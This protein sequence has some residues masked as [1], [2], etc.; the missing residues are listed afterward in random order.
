MIK[1]RVIV[2]VVLWA[3]LTAGCGG[4][5]MTPQEEASWRA[6]RW[7]QAKV[8]NEK[9]LK[10]EVSQERGL[11]WGLG[12]MWEF[13][14][15][16]LASMLGNTPLNSARKTQDSKDA[17]RRREGVYELVQRDFGKGPLY[18]QLYRQMA[19]GD[20]DYTVR[21]A[22]IRALNMCRDRQAVDVFLGGLEDSKELVRMEAAKAMANVPDERT[23]GSL[24]KH[25]SHPGESKDVR[26]A[27]SAALGN[28]RRIEV[29]QA[30]IRVLQDRDFGVSWQARKSLWLMTGQDYRYDEGAW[31]GYLT[32][33]HKPF[34]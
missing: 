13:P 15:Q 34:G 30:L 22:A 10:G 24:I 11:L 28:F 29:A 16:T 5:G 4:K 1:R 26:I 21:A 31:L 8:G 20:A 23:A 2:M 33:A 3:G 14:G 27:C 7:E 6:R 19:V 25:L 18:R 12:E 9:R 32:S 17:D